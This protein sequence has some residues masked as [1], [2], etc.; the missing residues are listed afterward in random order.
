M[1]CAE[2]IFR[3]PGKADITADVDFTHLALLGERR[4]WRT[5]WFGHQAGLEVV[6][7]ADDA[8]LPALRLGD[9]TTQG[10]KLTHYYQVCGRLTSAS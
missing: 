6:F 5:E 7:S 2:G 9:V 1:S 8:A 10:S 3:C 4:G